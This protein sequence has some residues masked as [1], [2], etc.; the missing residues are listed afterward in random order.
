MIVKY[1]HG[2]DLTISEMNLYME[3]TNCKQRAQTFLER[4]CSVPN[5][6]H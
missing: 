1:R 4:N 3:M 2:N 5:D 6:E